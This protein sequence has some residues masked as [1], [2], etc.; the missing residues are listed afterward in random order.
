MFITAQKIKL[1]FSF[2]SAVNK[3][4][5]VAN[6][7]WM[8]VNTRLSVTNAL[9]IPITT[10][11]KKKDDDV[12]DNRYAYATLQHRVRRMG[13]GGVRRITHFKYYYYLWENNDSDQIARLSTNLGTYYIHKNNPSSSWIILLSA[14]IYNIIGML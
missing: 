13:G 9:I 2:S 8:V 5:C 11:G 1:Y 10:G 12:D 4:A 3:R 6:I 7:S 14:V